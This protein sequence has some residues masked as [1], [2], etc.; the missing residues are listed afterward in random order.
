MLLQD[1]LIYQSVS[2]HSRFRTEPRSGTPTTKNRKNFLLVTF[3]YLTLLFSPGTFSS[4][5]TYVFMY[6]CPATAISVIRRSL[7]PL[8]SF[9]PAFVDPGCKILQIFH[10]INENSLPLSSSALLFGRGSKKKKKKEPA[11]QIS[12]LSYFSLMYQSFLGYM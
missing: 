12:F 1:W 9:L 5:Q 8:E 3:F 4:F 6:A 2:L 11:S 10:G 7:M